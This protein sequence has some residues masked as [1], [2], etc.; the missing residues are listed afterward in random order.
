V[1][2]LDCL[3]GAIAADPARADDSDLHRH[4]PNAAITI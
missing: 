2:A 3:A 4:T 1:S